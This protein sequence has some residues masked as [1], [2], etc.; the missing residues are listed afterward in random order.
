MHPQ[1]TSYR[2]G[3]QDIQADASALVED[4]DAAALTTA[5]DGG[6]WSIVQLFDHMNTAGWLLLHS[7]EDAIQSGQRKG[8]YGEPP[9]EYGFVSRW[10]VRSMQPSS[11]WTFTAPSVFEPDPPDTLHPNEVVEEFLGLQEEFANCVTAAEGLDLRRIR[12]PSPA[13]PLLRISLGAWFEATLAHEERHLAQAREVLRRLPAA[14][15]TA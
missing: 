3:F 5:P 12:V 9:F 11:G 8:T 15:A 2:R 7:L 14:D 13:V 10:F 1:L 6:T 4:R